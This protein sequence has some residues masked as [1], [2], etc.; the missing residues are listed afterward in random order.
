MRAALLP[1]S[2]WLPETVR[3]ARDAR[4]MAHN[5]EIAGSKFLP[6]YQAQR[7]FLEQR[8]GLLHAVG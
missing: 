7:P 5:P 1:R 6:R 2:T 4:R 8:K 3:D